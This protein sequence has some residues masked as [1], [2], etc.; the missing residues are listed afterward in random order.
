M[1]PQ[2]AGDKEVTCLFHLLPPIVGDGRH[3]HLTAGLRLQCQHP[4]V[5]DL[6]FVTDDQDVNVALLIEGPRRCAPVYRD[7]DASRR[8][9]LDS[10]PGEEKDHAGPLQFPDGEGVVIEREDP[11]CAEESDGEK[12]VP[13]EGIGI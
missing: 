6:T 3:L 9:L 13:L 12:S 11:C 4:V 5:I 1:I 7:R 2:N 8:Y 10:G